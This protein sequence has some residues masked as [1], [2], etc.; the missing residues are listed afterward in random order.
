M[1]PVVRKSKFYHSQNGRKRIDISVLYLLLF[2][3]ILSGLGIGL[4][5]A[6]GSRSWDEDTLCIS[7][8]QLNGYVLQQETIV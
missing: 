8:F 3:V 7:V 2:L 6:S 4:H 1:V 5:G